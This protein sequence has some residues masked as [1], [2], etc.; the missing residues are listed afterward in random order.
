MDGTEQ[1]SVPVDGAANVPGLSP[2]D[3]S[4]SGAAGAA[5]LFASQS[6]KSNGG[7]GKPA[8]SQ[9]SGD[10]KTAPPRI[11]LR[12]LIVEDSE[13]DAVLLE[14]ELQRTGYDTFCQ[15]V[16]TSSAMITALDQHQWDV[17]IADYVMPHF[18][19]LAALALVKERGLDLPFIIVSGHIT[20]ATAVG[21]MKAGAH[22]Y[23]MKDNLTRL[24]PAVER[25]L[26]EARMRR[27]R[28]Q[29]EERLMIERA[30]R[31]AV[32]KSIP[33]GIAA[34]D[35]DGRQTYVNPAFCAMV[36]Q[37]EAELLGARP[38]FSYWPPEQTKAIEDALGKVAPGVPGSGL[39]LRFRRRNGERF[40]AYVQITPLQDSFGNVTGWVSA[41][42]DVTE[43]KRGEVRL[44]AEHDI[45]RVL[46]NTPSLSE[47]A[48]KFV[49]ALLQGLE[50]DAGALWVL[51]PERTELTLS[52]MEARIASPELDEFSRESRKLSFASGTLLP[53]QVWKDRRATSI[54]DLAEAQQ[55]KRHEV[56]ARAGFRSALAYPIQDSDEF[57]GVLEFFTREILLPDPTLTNMM[58]AIGSEIAQFIKRRRAEE[59]LLRAHAEL[60]HRV[61]SRTA[62]LKSANVKLQAAI[63]ER[64]RLEHELLE[65][66]D[67]ERRRIGL[68]LHDDLGQKLSGLSLMTKGL[69]LTLAKRQAQ[70]AR[71]AGKVHALVQE[72]MGHAR[73]LARDLATLDSKKTDLP[74]ALTDLAARAKELF[75]IPCQFKSDKDVP[76]LDPSVTNQ[77]YKIVQEAVSNAVKHGKAKRIGIRLANG[78]DRLLLTIHNDGVPFP[79]H[80][81]QFTGMGLRIMNYRANLIGATLEVKAGPKHGTRVS[82]SYPL[83]GK[84]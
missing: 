11:S 55:L 45:T 37:T 64:R 56:A 16:E 52:A 19:G 31:T 54:S 15:V 21:A 35:L 4:L 68:D 27:E 30:F 22:D 18:N 23:V 76:P 73:D 12:A 8:G 9:R 50:V 26:R 39:E 25:E 48:P 78:S 47:A 71:D 7:N 32:E 57:F 3:A 80:K 69:E 75:R 49:K 36:G 58:T 28:R 40:D 20:E 14:I 66:T 51:N 53:G 67:K 38:P 43:R 17:V 72:A 70:E 10:A 65:I 24:G 74:A 5:A 61:Q 77:L 33:C 29:S 41:V 44:A 46:A 63:T 59:D 6:E 81:A 79:D 2:E 82:C 42:S 62:D 60:E 34:V 13:N 1:L 84:D 83:Q